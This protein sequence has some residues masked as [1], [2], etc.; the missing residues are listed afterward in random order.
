LRESLSPSKYT[1][2]VALISSIHETSNCSLE[3]RCDALMENVKIDSSV[4]ANQSV[5]EYETKK[6]SRFSQTNGV[7]LGDTLMNSLQMRDLT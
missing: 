4:A 1:S 3:E 2:C 7:S 5:M 6:D